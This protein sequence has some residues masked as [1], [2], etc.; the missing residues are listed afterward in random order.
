MMNA[1]LVQK[2][3]SYRLLKSQIISITD[4]QIAHNTV[5][6]ETPYMIYPLEIIILRK[7]CVSILP[8]F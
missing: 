6:F 1:V 5:L 4:F 7:R 3:A 2:K 8:S